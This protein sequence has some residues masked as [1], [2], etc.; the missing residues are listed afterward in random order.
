MT[1]S[2]L[3]YVSSQTTD[4]IVAWWCYATPR[5]Q[6]QLTIAGAGLQLLS[7]VGWCGFIQAAV[8]RRAAVVEAAVG[9]QSCCSTY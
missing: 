7:A 4:T 9:M 8:C 5:E 1:R 3:G 6:L 2:Y